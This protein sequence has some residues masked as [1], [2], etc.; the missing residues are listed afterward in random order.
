MSEPINAFVCKSPGMVNGD[1][2]V[3]EITNAHGQHYFKATQPIGSLFGQEVHGCCS[4][5]GR[6]KEQALQ[7]LAEDKKKLN[8]SLWI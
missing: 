2:T 4:G 3:V 6:T 1:I 5:I 7:R 8:E